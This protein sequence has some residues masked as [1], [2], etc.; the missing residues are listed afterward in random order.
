MKKL[1]IL[2]LI[3]AVSSMTFGFIFK[4]TGADAPVGL[5]IG[6]KAPELKFMN[7]E[8]KAIA[9]SSLK[10][11]MVLLDFWA[12]WCGPCRMENPA[13]VE[14]YHNYKDKKFKGGK[15]FTIYSVSLDN[16]KEAWIRAI[17]RDHL[18]WENH[19]S[20][21]GGWNS[22]PAQMYRVNSIPFNYL[23]NE[24]GVIIAK[25]LRGEDLEAELKKLSSK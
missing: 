12:S 3:L 5:N 6:N 1:N 16:S 20:D 8:G 14:A 4:N 18:V 25:N 10:G 21:L 22:K 9:L 24:N 13:V 2:L 23:L 7:P 11:K 17:E 19:V 15:G